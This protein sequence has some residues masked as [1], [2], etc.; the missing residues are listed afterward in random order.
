MWQLRVIDSVFLLL[1][2]FVARRGRGI[3]LVLDLPVN[4]IHQESFAEEINIMQQWDAAGAKRA[5]VSK[6]H[7]TPI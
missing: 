1:T 2:S 3:W 7:A 6:I 5:G 4:Q